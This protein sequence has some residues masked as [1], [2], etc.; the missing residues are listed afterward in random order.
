MPGNETARLKIAQ[1][2]RQH[3]LRNATQSV[4][5]LS[6]SLRVLLQDVEDIEGPLADEN[7]GRPTWRRSAASIVHCLHPP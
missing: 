2:P 3:A 5:Q 6:M 7:R 4:E 1:V